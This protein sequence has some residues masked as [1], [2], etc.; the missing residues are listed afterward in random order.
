MVEDLRFDG[1]R[2][3]VVEDKQAR[4]GYVA[5]LQAHGFEVE[6]AMTVEDALYRIRRRHYHLAWIDLGL[7]EFNDPHGTEGK[8]IS[9]YLSDIDD[10][11]FRLIVTVVK[12]ANEANR[13]LREYGAHYYITK[14]LL[15]RTTWDKHLRTIKEGIASYSKD[16]E[17]GFVQLKYALI[18]NGEEE[19][20]QR[21]GNEILGKRLDLGYYHELLSRVLRYI[22]PVA[23]I[24]GQD[25]LWH[26]TELGLCKHIWSRAHGSMIRILIS[27]DA[28]SDT[29]NTVRS[30]KKGPA[31]VRLDLLPDE[32]FPFYSA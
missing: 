6:E 8:E 20:F 1:K 27:Q 17:I 15:D 24:E 25:G 19:T 28:L 12:D 23:P 16:D 4:Q 22:W 9:K 13:I 14:D 5:T 11:T 32:E 18:G 3:L 31:N 7:D 30:F 2:A 29:A 10:K 21:L 26:R